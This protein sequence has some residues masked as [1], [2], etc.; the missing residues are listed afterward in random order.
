MPNSLNTTVRLKEAGKWTVFCNLFTDFL[1]QCQSSIAFHLPFMEPFVPG[2][3]TFPLSSGGSE[4]S[5][6]IAWQ[7]T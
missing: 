5:I 4:G 2:D 3:N 7:L 6:K 1:K